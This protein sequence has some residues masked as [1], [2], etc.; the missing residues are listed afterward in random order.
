MGY[1][2]T[3]PRPEE[4]HPTAKNRVWGFFV[5]PNKSR[6]ANRLQAPQPRRE[7]DPTTTKTASGVFFYGHR[8]Y[9]PVT[10]RWPSRDPIGERG[11][12]NLYGFV[13][14]DGVD[15]WDFLGREKMFFETER[16]AAEAAGKEGLETG[17][18]EYTEGIERTKK[19]WADL[20][21][22]PREYGG[23]ICKKCFIRENK[24][25]WYYTYTIGAGR[26]IARNDM[27]ADGSIDPVQTPECPYD[28]ELA[29][30][31]HAHPGR[32]RNESPDEDEKKTWDWGWGGTFSENDRQFVDGKRRPSG[33]WFA[34][35]KGKGLWMSRYIRV[36]KGEEEGREI[37][38]TKYGG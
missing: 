19:R 10:G 14:N 6:P 27:T 5:E 26:W 33:K 4:T 1:T 17:E 2:A 36:V 28:W 3:Y 32:L 22:S 23:R 8:Y 12:V 16:A 18:K 13:G 25:I 31:W 34:K 38:T 11:G 24:L 30:W 21:R 9:D 29:S 15:F 20:P 35:G 37:E 7:I